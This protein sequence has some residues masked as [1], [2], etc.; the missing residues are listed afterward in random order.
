MI[1]S[2]YFL[3][4]QAL[5]GSVTKKQILAGASGFDDTMFSLIWAGDIDGD[6]TLDLIMDLST[7]YNSSNMTLFLSSKAEEGQLLKKVSCISTKGC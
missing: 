5:Q 6:G 4:I 3:E 7:H 2:H 1:L